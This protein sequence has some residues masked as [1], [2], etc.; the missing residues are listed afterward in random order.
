[1]SFPSRS[2][3]GGSSAQSQGRSRGM[4]TSEATFSTDASSRSA[5]LAIAMEQALVLEQKLEEEAGSSPSHLALQRM[6]SLRS[7]ISTASSFAERQQAA[8]GQDT[9][10]R[11]IGKGSIGIIFEH[12]GTIHCYKLPL[13]DN[14]DKLWNNYTVHTKVQEAFD[15]ANKIINIDVKIPK[16]FWFANDKTAEFWDA[17]LDKFP[18]TEQ[19]PKKTRDTLCME[20]VLPLPQ[21]LR[22]HLIDRYCPRDKESAKLYLPN[23]DCLVRPLLGRRRRGSGTIAFSLRSF[24][25]HLDQFEELKLDLVEYATAMADAMA[26]LH[27]IAK[28]DAMDIEFVIGS[29]PSEM[30]SSGIPLTSAQIENLQPGKSTYEMAKAKDFKRRILCLWVLDF[31]A[32]KSIDISEAGARAAVKAFMDTD[33][34]CPRPSQD[35]QVHELWKSFGR[36]YMASYIK[37]G[38]DKRFPQSFLCGVEAEVKANRTETPASVSS[39]ISRTSSG[40]TSQTHGRGRGHGYGQLRRQGSGSREGSVRDL[41]SNWRK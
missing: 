18:F 30:H 16:M 20:R 12:P 41:S 32:C 36:R 17:N 11:E 28:I 6:L 25:L 15:T 38:A 13:L 19:F 22:N 21:P 24:R 3:P 4:N 23:R 5:S 27:C 10:F 33:A 35:P 26:V 9:E 40:A 2:P 1:M 29:A 14:S 39:T 37:F 8:V 31:D 34:Y 7:V